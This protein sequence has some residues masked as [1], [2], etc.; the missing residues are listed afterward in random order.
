MRTHVM[1]FLFTLIVCIFIGCQP[2]P[3]G[4]SPGDQQAIR[5]TGDEALKI[6]NTTADWDAY[7]KLYYAQDAVVNGPNAPAI[8][9]HDAI[10]A[11]F[12]SFPAI[13]DFKFEILEIN[14]AGNLAYVHGTYSMVL[15]PPGVKPM[16]DKGKFLEIWKRQA[17]GSWKVAIDTFNSDLPMVAPE[18][19][20]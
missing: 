18:P 10:V 13:S 9:G 3:Q 19:P 12:K 17:D 5:R 8:K 15:T 1:L 6:A 2:P 14:G 16:S 4:L 11:M 20:K 7:T